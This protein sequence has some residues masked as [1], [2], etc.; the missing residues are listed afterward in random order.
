[1][2]GDRRASWSEAE[3]AEY[4]RFVREHHPD[5]GGDPEAFEA[6]L[7]R[8][9]ERARSVDAPLVFVTRERGLRR[10][11]SV[12]ATRRRRRRHPRVM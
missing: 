12:F 8:F 5:V 10:L 3:R 1:M 4:R 6:G 2:G 7:R 9:R 11:W